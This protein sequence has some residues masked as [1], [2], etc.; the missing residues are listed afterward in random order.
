MSDNK[1]SN[2][3]RGSALI[4]IINYD[5]KSRMGGAED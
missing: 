4:L 5:I 2:V 1:R 3:A